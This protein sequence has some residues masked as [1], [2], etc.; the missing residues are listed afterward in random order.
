MGTTMGTRPDGH[1][2]Q[3]ALFPSESLI[4]FLEYFTGSDSGSEI[5]SLPSRIKAF[6][7]Y[8]FCHLIHHLISSFLYSVTFLMSFT[9]YNSHVLLVLWAYSIPN[10]S[11]ASVCIFESLVKAAIPAF[12]EKV[13]TGSGCA[14]ITLSV[15]VTAYPALR[16]PCLTKLLPSVSQVSS[17]SS[18]ICLSGL[19]GSSPSRRHQLGRRFMGFAY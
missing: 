19:T 1:I 5:L 15:A 8:L 13:P 9:G 3:L 4:R 7:N 10:T 2:C 17:A 16:F 14:S 6:F 11:W 18:R 12:W